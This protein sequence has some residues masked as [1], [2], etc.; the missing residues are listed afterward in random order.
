MDVFS[1]KINCHY[2]NGFV[3]D[4]SLTASFMYFNTLWN[5][6][7]KMRPKMEQ[8]ELRTL[9]VNAT[10]YSVSLIVN[11]SL[12][13]FPLLF[14]H[15]SATTTTPWHCTSAEAL[16]RTRRRLVEWLAFRRYESCASVCTGTVTVC[17]GCGEWRELSRQPTAI[18]RGLDPA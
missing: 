5:K 3:F 1:K 17:N 14:S 13:P 18:F 11:L 6:P 4:W 7:D 2:F 9:W 16:L 12:I 8:R 10:A 15:R